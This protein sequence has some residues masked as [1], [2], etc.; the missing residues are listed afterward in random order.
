MTSRLKTA[1]S[2]ALWCVAWE[3][4]ARYF[5]T[6]FFP[7]LTMIAQGIVSLLALPSFWAALADTARAFGIGM[8]IAIGIGVPA[9]L[10]I[11]SSA[12]AD[13]LSNVWINIFISAPLTAVVPALIPLLGIGR[14]TVVATVVLFAIW[15]IILDTQAGIRK[16]NGSLIDMARVFGA[17]RTQRFRLI[18]LPG[19]LPEILAGIRLG[20]VRGIKGV[21]IGQ[22]L[23]S[24]TGLGAMFDDL[25]NNFQMTQF[26]GLIV[27]VFAL[28]YGL[29]ELIEMIERRVEFYA[30]AR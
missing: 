6:D 5:A 11:G 23:V 16:I 8:A 21:V 1:A 22:I 24:V 14:A 13:R 26:W 15:V 12:L 30:P 25:V 27:I 9:G 29:V 18:L 19:A 10:V 20:V 28:S 7:P 3:A 17:S 2:L 4:A